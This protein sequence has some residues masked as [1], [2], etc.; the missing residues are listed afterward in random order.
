MVSPLLMR[1]IREINILKD[2]LDTQSKR[3]M[4]S[5]RNNFHVLTLQQ[6]RLQDV[7]VQVG[8]RHVFFLFFFLRSYEDRADD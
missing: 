8:G 5:Q 2:K 6:Q 4:G 3:E 7:K 1:L